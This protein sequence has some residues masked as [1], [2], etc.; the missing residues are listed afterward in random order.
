MSLDSIEQ[1]KQMTEPQSPAMSRTQSRAQSPRPR[2]DTNGSSDDYG[3]SNIDKNTLIH[4][5]VENQKINVKERIQKRSCKRGLT[6][7]SKVPYL[8]MPPPRME[9]IDFL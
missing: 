3:L 4:R 7:S 8:L 9:L 6:K 5:L 2:L 1:G